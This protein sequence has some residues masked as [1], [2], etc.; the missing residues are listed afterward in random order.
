[1]PVK[2]PD[3]P[4]GGVTE[5]TKKIEEAPVQPM[6][7]KGKGEIPAPPNLGYKV[8]PVPSDEEM[9]KVLEAKLTKAAANKP[10]KV[11][12]SGENSI[13]GNKPQEKPKEA[14]SFLDEL[15]AHLAQ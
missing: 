2:C 11:Q 1:M 3:V 8:P 7:K 10:K 5:G 13:I 6:K 12:F 9:K 4:K 14:L 15:E